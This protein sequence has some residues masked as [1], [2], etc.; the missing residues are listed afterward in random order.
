M[1]IFE[2]LRREGLE[3]ERV[4]D[5]DDYRVRG[6]DGRMFRFEPVF[7]VPADLLQEYLQRMSASYRD[8][9][10]PLGEALSLTR[11]HATEYLTTDHGGGCNATTSLG[12][13][14]TRRGDVEFYV[15]QEE[16]DGSA[17]PPGGEVLEWTAHRRGR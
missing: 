5:S 6:L 11:M 13:R 1:Q 4:G 8:R 3:F 14:R 9:P 16:P 17:P 12:F 10:D 7:T 2:F 15:E